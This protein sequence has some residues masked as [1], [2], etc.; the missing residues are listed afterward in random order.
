MSSEHKLKDGDFITQTF[1]TNNKSEIIFFTD[2][3]QA[4]KF[5]ISA[6]DCTKAS[7]LGEYIPAKLGFDENENIVS[8]VITSDYSGFVMF[9]Y[10][11]GKALK[12]P[13]KSYETKTNRKKL[14]NAYS[15][16]SPLVKILF[17]E[18]DTDILIRTSGNRAVL[19]N[20][21]LV[22]LKTTRDS[23]GIQVI[24]P[25]A[26]YV[27]SSAETVN[28]ENNDNLEKYRINNIPAV[29]LLAK[30]LAGQNQLSFE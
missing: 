5:K 17:L 6:F 1:E 30:T 7:V 10:E 27:L 24:T 19:L 29:G 2:K 11:N 22:S 13:L 18:E 28:T 16:K 25:K 20:T 4:Y 23:A 12:V 26:K 14:A 8:S 21:S 15:N 9:F 3:Y